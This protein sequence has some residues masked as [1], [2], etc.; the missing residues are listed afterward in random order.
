MQYY[1]RKYPDEVLGLV[2]VDSTY[3]DDFINHA[4]L[5]EKME[6]QFKYLA[7]YTHSFSQKLLALPMTEVSVIALVA[8]NER[9]MTQ[10]E[11]LK[12]ISESM[13]ANAKKH[14]S[15]YPNCK[16]QMVDTGH[17]VMYEKPEVVSGA[18]R[19]VIENLR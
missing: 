3:P 6:K 14:L 10:K 8:T 18:I 15:L 11:E 9:I 16:V 19:E 7:E 17:V 4:N 2:L 12:P 1:A 13:I 5:T